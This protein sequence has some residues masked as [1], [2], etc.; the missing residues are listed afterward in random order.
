MVFNLALLAV[1]LI[2]LFGVDWNFMVGEDPTQNIRN[3][4][5]DQHVASFLKKGAQDSYFRVYS[6][7]YS[8][9]QRTAAEHQIHLADGVDPLQLASYWSYMLGATGVPSSGYSVTI[10]DFAGGKPAVDNKTYTPDAGKLGL[11]NV[12]YVVAEYDLSADGLALIDQI[13]STRIYEN[14]LCQPR[15][16]VE[17]GNGVTGDASIMKYSPD[18]IVVQAAGPGTLVLSEDHVPRLAGERGWESRDD[19]YLS[20]LVT[21]RGAASRYA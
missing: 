15:A 1:L 16:W 19:R 7:S 11:L 13:G 10:P 17:M 14:C 4:S 12:C 8:L 2:N 9:P 21:Q 3:M 20:R 6:P 5:Q 18:R